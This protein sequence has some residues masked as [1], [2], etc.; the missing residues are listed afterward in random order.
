M[1]RSRASRPGSARR[2]SR[3]SRASRASTGPPTRRP[4]P[5]RR[6]SP[7]GSR[8]GCPSS[9]EL[10]A[11]LAHARELAAQRQFPQRD[12][13]DPELPIV[14]P[15]PTRDLAAAL[16]ARRAGVAGELR[17]LLLDLELL[18]HRDVR[19]LELLAQRGPLRKKLK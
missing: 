6:R 7:C 8:G 1:T 18:V 12:A 13:R 9:S 2:R 19:I 11:R 16:E 10:P 15:R 14:R 3:G 4:S 17:E 5:S